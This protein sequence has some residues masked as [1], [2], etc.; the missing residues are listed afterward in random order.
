MLIATPGRMLDLFE[1]G[2]VLLADVKILVIDEADR[3]LDMG[4]IP[5]IERIVGLLP[6]LR[7]TLF[8]SATMP[9]EIRRLS[10]AFLSNPKQISVAPPATTADTV[11][12]SVVIVEA[13]D[14]RKALRHLLRRRRHELHEAARPRRALGRDEEGRLLPHEGEEEGAVDHR[15]FREGPARD[16]I[17]R[18]VVA[19]AVLLGKPLREVQRHRRHVAAVGERGEAREDRRRRLA[20]EMPHFR[21]GARLLADPGFGRVFTD[22]MAIIEYDEQE[23]WH[24]ARITARMPFTMDPAAPVLHYAQE[25]FEGLK[26]YKREMLQGFRLYGEMHR[27]IPI[28]AAAQGARVAEL[29]VAHHARKFGHSKYGLN[30]TI[31]VLLDLLVVKF[32]TKYRTKPIYLFGQAGVGLLVLAFL[33]GLWALYLKFFDN[34]SFVQT[35]LPLLVS[36]CVIAGLMCLLMGLLAGTA[37][38]LINALITIGFNLPSFIATL[39]MFY[40]ARGLAA[41]IVAGKQLTGFPESFNLLGRK[42]GDILDHFGIDI[43]SGPL[44]LLSEAVSVQTLWMIVIAVIA[45]IILAYTPFGQMIYAT[46]GN[47]RAADYAGINTKRVRFTSLMFSA[48]CAT[49]AGIIYTAFF[50]SFNPTA[51]QFRELDAIA[52]VIIGGGSI[53]GGYGTMIGALAGAA[54]I[55]L[56]RA[57]LQLNII[58]PGGGSFV[59]PQHWVNVFTGLILIVAVLIDIWLRQANILAG[60]RARVGRFARAKSEPEH[61]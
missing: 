38:G 40:I 43:G 8:F 24:D 5:D 1:R 20:R 19:P 18:V 28:Y 32:L 39:G 57:L 59:M 6:P 12:Q 47:R 41:W 58:L 7:Q 55:T 49:M 56:I 60:L 54:V 50:R 46:G 30:R 16:G 17:E 29:P 44:R 10:D 23:G 22:H 33:A 27:F 13:E 9:P 42:V 4:F 31:K 45:G 14:K 3:M 21:L 26:A 15:P 2:K 36:L 34:T 48:L 11:E 51:G 53:F 25:I 37:A 35:P 61:A 52:A